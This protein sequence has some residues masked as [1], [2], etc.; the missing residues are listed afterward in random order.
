M[1][2]Y[3]L[4]L[5]LYFWSCD[6]WF[7]IGAV[8]ILMVL[9]FLGYLVSWV[10]RLP[11]C[12]MWPRFSLYPTSTGKEQRRACPASSGMRET[13]SLLETTV[14]H[15]GLCLPTIAVKAVCLFKLASRRWNILQTPGDTELAGSSLEITEKGMLETFYGRGQ[16]SVYVSRAVP[17]IHINLM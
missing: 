4:W 3:T 1:L 17:Q 8:L 13:P 14:K 10:W 12:T 15:G 7:W 9:K 16:V 2:V 5:F 11:S 6:I